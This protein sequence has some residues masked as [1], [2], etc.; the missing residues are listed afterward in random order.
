[1]KRMKKFASLALALVMTLAMMAPVFATGDDG[2]ITI[3]NAI[4]GE[5]YAIYRIFDL[6]SYNTTD[7]N[8]SYK[9]NESWKGFFA[10][11]TTQAGYITKLND[12]FVSWNGPQTGSPELAQFAKDALAYAITNNI[13]AVDAKPAPPAA[14]GEETSTVTFENVPLGWY[15]LDSS[16]GTLCSLN[17]TT[18]EVTINDKNEI[19]VPKKEQNTE[20]VTVG[21]GDVIDYTVEVEV[22][23]GAQN[24]VL[25]DTMSEGLTYNDDVAAVIKG[26]QTPVTLVPQTAENGETFAVKIDNVEQYPAGTVIVF[27]YSATINEDAVETNEVDNTAKVSFGEN[28][29]MTEGT[30]VTHKLF[31]LTVYKYAKDENDVEI[32]LTGAK[33]ELYDEK[34]GENKIALVKNADGSYRPA[35]EEE[36]TATG[37]ESAVIEAGNV[38]VKGLA[39]GTYYLEEIEAPEGY[40]K[41]AERVEVKLEK[42]HD[43]AMVGTDYT[44]EVLNQTGAQL[45]STGGIGT[46][47]FYVVGGILVAGAAILLVTRKRVEEQ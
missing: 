15:L 20:K 24:Y 28:N 34:T 32:P 6:A 23:P 38:V 27:S 3:N 16:M 42:E 12:D 41:L 11:E 39:Q 7:G 8:Q 26:T 17:T 10:E 2:K 25:H 14:D 22:K 5:E 37:F 47:I 44:A 9:I 1:M 13:G 30:K 19:P 43:G 45:P 40:N 4:P 21:V 18:P 31:N 46:T 35:T 29:K 36:K 33:F